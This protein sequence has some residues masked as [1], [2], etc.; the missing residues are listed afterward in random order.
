MPRIPVH[1]LDS[2]PE[3]A[4]PTLEKL[5]AQMGTLLNIHAEMAHSP[6][7]LAAYAG[8]QD[9][10]A[11]HGSFDAA[12]Q[13]A[14]ALAV[15]AV[16]QCDYCQSAHTLG[17]KV[18]GLT[19]QQTVDIREGRSSGDGKLDAL[20]TLVREAAGQVGHV[21]D[22]SWKQALDAGWTDT[23]LSEAFVHLTVNLYT[24]YFNHYVGTEL[25]I[26][27]APGIAA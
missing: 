2:A 8:I 25:D 6:V 4:R 18:A 23:E 22:G 19:E 21:E 16:D 10:I 26:P 7:V 15:G 9:A 14:I 13:E 11:Q 1:T 20:L 24:N 17:G 5:Q 3:Q 27:A 12:T